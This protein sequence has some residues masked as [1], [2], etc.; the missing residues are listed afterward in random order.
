LR[1]GR[2]VDS[3]GMRTVLIALMALMLADFA[4]TGH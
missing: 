3:I 1:S 4:G 2:L